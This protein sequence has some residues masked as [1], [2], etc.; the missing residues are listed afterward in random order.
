MKKAVIVF[1]TLMVLLSAC[2]KEDD[3]EDNTIIDQALPEVMYNDIAGTE[4]QSYQVPESKPGIL[5]DLQG[6][7]SDED[8]NIIFVCD[9]PLS[10]CS[11][12]DVSSGEVVL[13]TDLIE[14]SSDEGYHYYADITSLT[15]PGTYYAITDIIGRSYDFKISDDIY[16]A[17]RRQ[18]VEDIISHQKTNDRY[19]INESQ[20]LSLMLMA[21]ELNPDYFEDLD[22]NGIAD[23]LDAARNSASFLLTMQDSIG[24]VAESGHCDDPDADDPV[25]TRGE[26]SNDATLIYAAALANFA[27]CY[28]QYN[29]DLADQCLYSAETAYKYVTLSQVEDYNKEYCYM[30]DACLYK[31]TGLEEYGIRCNDYKNANPDTSN[32]IGD[33][34]Y[35][36][37]S[38]TADIGVCT[39]IINSYAKKAENISNSTSKDNYF[40]SQNISSNEDIHVKILED[41][42]VMSYM[43]YLITNKEYRTVIQ[44]HMHYLCGE[45]EDSRDYLKDEIL[46]GDNYLYYRAEELFILSSIDVKYKVPEQN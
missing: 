4:S 2:G 18:T 38:K 25:W 15:E 39:S 29:G 22:G 10:G 24:A 9:K 12:I 1:L 26:D 40:I 21:Y 32:F 7:K 36:T 11:I 27:R 14:T 33:Y 43:N 3:K 35:L 5:V 23:I 13:T 37:T 6:Y 16:S 34:A 46:E 28:R 17:M 45:N 20:A 19:V 8:K 30:A 41:M 31:T 44:N 42:L